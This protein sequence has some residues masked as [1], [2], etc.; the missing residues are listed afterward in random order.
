MTYLDIFSDSEIASH[1]EVLHESCGQNRKAVL[2]ALRPEDTCT[3]PE[4][5]R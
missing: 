1:A 3:E 4:W 2:A 5:C